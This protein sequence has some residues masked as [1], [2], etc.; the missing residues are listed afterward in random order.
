MVVDVAK[1]HAE[2]DVI[3][4]EDVMPMAGPMGIRAGEYSDAKDADL[5]VITAGVPRKPGETRL[6]LVSK[7]PAS[8]S[9]L[10]AQ[11]LIAALMAFS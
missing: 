8:S 2:G 4:L 3:D 7:T 6:D 5:V 10:C 1:D 9:Q 11:L